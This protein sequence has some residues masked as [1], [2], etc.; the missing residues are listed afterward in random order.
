MY[1]AQFCPCNSTAQ[2]S[3]IIGTE[4]RGIERQV[5]RA[6]ELEQDSFALE[7][8]FVSTTAH[9]HSRMGHVCSILDAALSL[10]GYT[11]LILEFA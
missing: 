9:I 1:R 6:R 7:Y 5:L 3:D 10:L 11:V 8:S 2:L 4:G